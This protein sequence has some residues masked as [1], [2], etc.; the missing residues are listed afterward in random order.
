[1][2]Y[3]IKVKVEMSLFLLGSILAITEFSLHIGLEILLTSLVTGVIVQNFSSHGQKFISGINTF[4]LPINIIF[5]CFAGA[6]LQLELLTEALL[7]TFILVT[8][9]FL[10]NYAGNYVGP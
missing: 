1:M 3:F 9:R 7:I 8:G 2:W 10:L 4:S 6:R 5:L